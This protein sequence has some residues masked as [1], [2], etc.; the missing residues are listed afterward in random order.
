VFKL[1]PISRDAIPRCLERG[2]RY[3]LMGEPELAESICRDI[4]RV[5]PQNQQAL[6]TLLLALTDQFT[7][8]NAE[9]VRQANDVLARLKGEYE[10]RYYAGIICER[11]GLAASKRTVLGS[12]QIVSEFLRQAMSWYEQAEAVRPAGNDDAVIRWNACV[13]LL[14]RQAQQGTG[15]EIMQA[16]VCGR[17]QIPKLE[18]A[19]SSRRATPATTGAR[20]STPMTASS[21]RSRAAAT[22]PS[23]CCWC[24][25]STSRA[26][27]SCR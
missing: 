9:I 8:D 12:G 22:T 5:D 26:V 21:S 14:Q 16:G 10:R 24:T 13:R 1:K 23:S 17:V 7:T 20:D 2:D 18:R 11:R 19:S 15:S 4:L 3:R 6:V 25:A 27:L